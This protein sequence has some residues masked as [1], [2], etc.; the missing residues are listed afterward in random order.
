MNTL[1]RPSLTA[2]LVALSLAALLGS[3]LSRPSRIA[4]AA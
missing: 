3:W 4:N 2:G 1:L